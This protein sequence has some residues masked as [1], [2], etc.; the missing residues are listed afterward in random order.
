MEVGFLVANESETRAGLQLVVSYTKVVASF[1]VVIEVA[2]S[3]KIT[4]KI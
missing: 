4:I 3:F 2:I 1:G